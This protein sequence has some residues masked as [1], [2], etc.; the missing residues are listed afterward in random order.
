MIN[1]INCNSIKVNITARGSCLCYDCKVV[2]PYSEPSELKILNYKVE[3]L[4]V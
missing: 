4:D 3:V 1:C 2:F